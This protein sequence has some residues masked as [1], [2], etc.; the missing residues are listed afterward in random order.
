MRKCDGGFLITIITV[1]FS[2]LAIFSFL[3]LEQMMSTWRPSMRF[4]WGGE[5]A[6]TGS[7]GQVTKPSVGVREET[8]AAAGG[9]DI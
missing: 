4:T 8:T 6:G 9:P 2:L 1:N 5:G 3:Q 7:A